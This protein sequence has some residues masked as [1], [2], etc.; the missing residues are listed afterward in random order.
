MEHLEHA[1]ERGS[2]YIGELQHALKVGGRDTDAIVEWIRNLRG[3]GQPKLKSAQLA[4][5]CS[6]LGG[7]L[8]GVA[9]ALGLSDG[10]LVS[11]LGDPRSTRHRLKTMRNLCDCASPPDLEELEDALDEL[12]RAEE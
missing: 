9:L 5:R 11:A 6:F 3:G 10:D 4:C 2:D 1:V 12:E 7:A 8:H